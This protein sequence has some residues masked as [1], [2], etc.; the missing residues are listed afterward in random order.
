[1][2]DPLAAAL[3]RVA[4]ARV[5]GYGLVVE[6]RAEPGDGWLPAEGIASDPVVL[7]ELLAG[8][9]RVAGTD[10]GAVCAA[11]LVEK[12]A[13][14]VGS[15]AA[16]FT[17]SERALPDLARP[18]V[19]LGFHEGLAWGIALRGGGLT[20]VMDDRELCRRA[21][22]GIIE[23]LS[24]L[25]RAL[26][27]RGLRRERPL[28]RAVGDRVA[29]GF[30]WSG[31]GFEQ[32]DRADALARLTLEPELPISVPVRSLVGPKGEWLHRRVTCCLKHQTPSPQLCP[33]CPRGQSSSGRLAA[34]R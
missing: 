12:Y 8:V 21:R 9:A 24:P 29:Q 6:R 13:W 20:Q 2:T 33:D 14:Q 15:L 11:W 26:A 5:R 30:V 1:M 19:L 7:D 31:I 25:I 10:R 28:W 32:P 16:A 34:G 18:N 17:V 4:A 22:E 3:T 23:H 27:E